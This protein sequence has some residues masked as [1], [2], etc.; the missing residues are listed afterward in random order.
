MF[1]NLS[2]RSRSM[3]K[4]LKRNKIQRNKIKKEFKNAESFKI[5]NNLKLKMIESKYNF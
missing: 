2:K 4:P 1:P 5:T 3:A